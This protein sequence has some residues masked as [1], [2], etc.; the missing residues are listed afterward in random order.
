M[1]LAGAAFAYVT[2]EMLPVGLLSEISTDLDVTEGRV[3]L[4]LTFYAYGV[5]VLTL[6]LIGAVKTWPRRRVVVLTVATLA[7]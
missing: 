2:A 1:T 4:L 5:A 7:V 6:P 3:G